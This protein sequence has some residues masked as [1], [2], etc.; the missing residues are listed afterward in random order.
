[1]WLQRLPSSLDAEARYCT[2]REFATL[3]ADFSAD[4]LDI[5]EHADMCL[6]A[7]KDLNDA[8]ALYMHIWREMRDRGITSLPKAKSA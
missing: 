5:T 8:R 7:I 4:F 2:R 1:M 3:R 6:V